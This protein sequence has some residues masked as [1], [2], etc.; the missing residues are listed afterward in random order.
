MIADDWIWIVDHSV[1]L[2]QEKCLIILGIRACD[3]PRNRPLIYSDVEPI[4]M[5][6]VKESNGEIVYKQLE[7][8]LLP[9][10]ATYSDLTLPP[11]LI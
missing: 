7:C 11:I 9:K 5:I 3:L 10:F 8:V 1:Q 6:P 4:E 2:G